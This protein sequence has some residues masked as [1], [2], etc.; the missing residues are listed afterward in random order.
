MNSDFGGDR[1]LLSKCMSGDRKASEK[2]VRQFSDLVYRSVQYTL[3][4]KNVSFNRQDLEDL[5]NTVFLLLFEQ[6]CKKLRQYKGINGCSLASW[7]RMI[8]V[9]TV[10]D[11]LR[12]KGVDAM[13]WQ[14]KRVPLEEMPEL[15][16][17]EGGFWAHIDSAERTRVLKD[18]MQRLP[19]RDRL[20][21]KLHFE[22][23]LS[24]AEV[25]ETME[26]T[27]NTAYTVKHRAIQRLKLNMAAIS[28]GNP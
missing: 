23:G 10:L 22:Q 7:I 3:L 26:L 19:P 28:K 11:H 17:D 25:A 12:K 13:F 18:S 14:K 8:T 4:A 5:H 16:A 15:K 1:R 6:G 27:I 2:L 21:L 20:F 9:R 24:V